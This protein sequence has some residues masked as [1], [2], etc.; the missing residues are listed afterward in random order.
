[1]PRNLFPHYLFG[2]YVV[3]IAKL[4]KYQFNEI[5]ITPTAPKLSLQVYYGTPKAAFKQWLKTFNGKMQYPAINF[6]GIDYRRRYDKE[7]PNSKME[8]SD[9]RS[10]DPN[11]GTVTVTNPPM[12][13]DVTYQFSLYNN[14]MRERDHVLH[15]ILMM[16]TR[17]QCSLKWYPM[18]LVF[19]DI[20]LYMPLKLD[21]GFFD[22]TE[23]EGLTEK[24]TGDLIKTNF[25]I[26]SSAVLPYDVWR[27]PS[28]T[29]M[30]VNNIIEEED[31]NGM[32]IS[33]N[34]EIE[35]SL[36]GNVYFS[37]TIGKLGFESYNEYMINESGYYS[38]HSV[39]KINMF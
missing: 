19:P 12:H 24:E 35:K 6:Y 39:G 22:E 1:M 11:D 33:I 18:P 5:K 21:E 7:C 37:N 20:F 17:G 26:I 14:N 15:R 9:P 27:M 23:V 31:H 8:L 34:Q 13:Y 32:I 38:H 10:Y 30:L 4:F 25:N 2:N 29:K 28:V 16:F 3:E 36:F